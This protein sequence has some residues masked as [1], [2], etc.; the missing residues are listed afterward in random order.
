MPSTRKDT[1]YE[2]FVWIDI[3]NPSPADFN[4]LAQEYDLKYFQIRDSL[5]PGHLPKFEILEKHKFAILR[6]YTGEPHQRSSEITEITNK[7]AIFYNEKTVITV[8][9]T[10]FPFLTDQKEEFKNSEDL[11]VY[12][13]HESV[14]T[15][16]GPSKYLSDKTDE[17]EQSVFLKKYQRISLE[18]FY[19]HKARAR[20]LRHLLQITQ[21]VINEIRVSEAS[22]TALQ[23]TK[24]QL[25]FLILTYGEVLDDSY[26]LLQSYLSVNAQKNND[27][28]KLLTVFSAFFLPLTFIVGV[29]GMNFDNMPELRSQNGYFVVIG[30]MVLIS[31]GIF[32]W[33]KKNEIL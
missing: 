32:A 29:Y 2:N 20:I 23:D 27:V 24:D 31:A 1:Q 11:I 5:E 9:R 6:A 3:C 8:H 16:Q 25:V 21:A 14:Q 26:N 10:Q 12:L 13:I 18:D 30:L 7:I 15:F 33:F 28:M 19:F 4:Q 17:F 22:Q